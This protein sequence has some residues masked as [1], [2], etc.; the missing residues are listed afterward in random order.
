MA[1]ITLSALGA[2]ALAQCPGQWITGAGTIGSVGTANTVDALAVDR[3]NGDVYV[4]GWFIGG[5]G[6]VANTA[7]IARWNGSAWSALGTGTNGNVRAASFAPNHDLII[8]GDFTLAG[9]VANTLRVARWNGSAWSALGTGVNATVWAVAVL[10]N[11]NIV[12]GGDFTTAGGGAINR[13]ALFNG[14]TWTGLGAGGANDRVTSLAVVSDTG[15]I[16]AGGRFT[17]IGGVAASHVAR[18]NGSSW[19]AVGSGISGNVNALTTYD[20][21]RIAAGSQGGVHLWDGSTWQDLGV[22]LGEKFALAAL[23]GGDLVAAGYI[24]AGGHIVAWDGSNWSAIGSGVNGVFNGTTIYDLAVSPRIGGGADVFVGGA[25]T[26]ANGAPA[27]N[28]A[29]FRTT[30]PPPAILTQ[31]A[32]ATVL[33]G[34]P[35]RFFVAA[36][37]F[38]PITYQ[39]RQAGVNLVDGPTGSGS[40][41]AGAT[42]AALTISSAHVPDAGSYDCVLTSGCTTQSTPVSLTIQGL[43]CD[44]D[45]DHNGVVAVQD[46]FDFLNKWFAGCP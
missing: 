45:S 18:W 12:I 14:S 33:C 15:D 28:I 22:P 11:G 34:C 3:G 16:V 38:G 26:S 13:I 39:W 21:G 27:S 19:S 1:F 42:T 17:S 20:Q 10:P 8:G 2:P 29:Q 4:G 37:A 24:G 40:T 46:I 23:P 9:G 43:C 5:A 35:A 7:Y 36:T 6:G 31:P 32:A 30:T 44:A 41:I 25:F